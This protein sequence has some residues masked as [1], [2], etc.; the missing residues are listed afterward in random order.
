MDIEGAEFLAL[1]GMKSVLKSLKPQILIELDP[2]I[3]SKTGRN[4]AEIEAYLQSFGYKKY[5]IDKNGQ[6]N[7]KQTSHKSNNYIFKID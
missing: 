3:L 7:H 5:F 6:L 1:R 4:S 2:D